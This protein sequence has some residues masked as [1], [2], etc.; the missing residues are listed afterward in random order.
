MNDQNTT[1]SLEILSYVTE[2][3]YQRADMGRLGDDK[4]MRAA[5]AEAS[6]FVEDYTAAWGGQTARLA[7]CCRR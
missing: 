2:E 7:R 3:D 5:H 1:G 4:T 6:H